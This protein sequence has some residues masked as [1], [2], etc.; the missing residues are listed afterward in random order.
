MTVEFRTRPAWPDALSAAATAPGQRVGLELPL[1]VGVAI[2]HAGVDLTDIGRLGWAYGRQGFAL[3]FRLCGNA[4]QH[5]LA[6]CSGPDKV[7]LLA[8]AFGLK[9]SVIKACS[10][11]PSGGRFADIDTSVVLENVAA[12]LGERVD[13][14]GCTGPLGLSGAIGRCLPDVTLQG[15]VCRVTEQLLLCWTAGGSDAKAEAS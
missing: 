9:E 1:P 2:T 3:L 10:G 13:T 5:V 11:I 14:L 6:R 12:A 15:G 7:L 4:E 8:V